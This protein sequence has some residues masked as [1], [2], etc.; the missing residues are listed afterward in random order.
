MVMNNIKRVANL[1]Q[2]TTARLSA[3]LGGKLHPNTIWNY[4]NGKSEPTL[5]TLH[6]IAKALDVPIIELIKK[7]YRN[8]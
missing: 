6:L 1:K 2:I 8:E 4:Y 5:H 3:M 7:E